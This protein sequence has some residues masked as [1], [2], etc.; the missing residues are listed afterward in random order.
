MQ[1]FVRQ[2][3]LKVVHQRSIRTH[4]LRADS[5]TVRY[6]VSTDDLRHQTLQGFHEGALAQRAVVF[7]KTVGQYF[8]AMR[9]KP[10]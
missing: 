6:Q 3:E 1:H 2:N 9:Q 7:V 4:R 5:G 8:P 10:G